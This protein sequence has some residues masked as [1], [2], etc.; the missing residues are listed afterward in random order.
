MAAGDASYRAG[1]TL[2]HMSPETR[3]KIASFLP[4]VG[5]SASNPVDVLAPFPSPGALKGVLEAMAG[6]GE[7]G[8]IIVDK[9]VLSTELRR[10]MNYADQ[11]PA[12]DESWLS[13]I[14][15]DIHRSYGLPVIVVLRE[16]LDP[17][18]DF[19]VEAERLRLRR[20]YQENGVAVYPT[21][22]RAFRALG[23][24]IGYY[25]RGETA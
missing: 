3:E 22:D 13:E 24:V 6:S 16:N 12:E 20:Y 17:A 9:I 25:Q 21:A 19:A 8:A 1:L 15:I 18:G 14:P 11:S 10:L 5:S 4:P 7:V 23:H 2:P